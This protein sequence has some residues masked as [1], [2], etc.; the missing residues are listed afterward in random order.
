MKP[1][2]INNKNI[3]RINNA[4]A[5]AEG[6]AT[7]RTINYHLLCRSIFEIEVWLGIPKVAMTGIK[8]HIDYHA[9]TFPRA[10][11]YTPMSTHALVEKTRTGW[12]L[13]DVYRDACRAKRYTLT[14]TDTTKQALIER[15]EKF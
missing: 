14:L 11:K 8:A 3:Q 4:I 12:K 15:C 13:I 10:Y 9:Q 1:I 7:E 6:R 5:E 2:V